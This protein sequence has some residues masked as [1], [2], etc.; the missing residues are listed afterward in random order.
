MGVENALP[1]RRKLIYDLRPMRERLEKQVSC[2]KFFY[3]NGTFIY[4]V[5]YVFAFIAAVVYCA[6]TYL[7]KEPFLPE[8]RHTP[9]YSPT[10][11]N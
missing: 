7:P 6:V 1:P 10:L 11:R 9:T 3:N 4:I 5:F 2:R 8:H